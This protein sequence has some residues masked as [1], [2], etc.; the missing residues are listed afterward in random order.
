MNKLFYLIIFLFFIS[1]CSF[2]KNSKFWTSS[3]DIQKEKEE[4]LKKILI[5]ESA[6]EKEFNYKVK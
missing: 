1:A 2:N 5:E 6:V 4:K 3:Q